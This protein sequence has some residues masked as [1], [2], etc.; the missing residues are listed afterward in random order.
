MISVEGQH[1]PTSHLFEQSHHLHASSWVF[2]YV[3]EVESVY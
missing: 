3:Y 1:H 2:D